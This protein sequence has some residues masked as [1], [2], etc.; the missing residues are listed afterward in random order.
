[1]IIITDENP[2]AQFNHDCLIHPGGGAGCKGP[3]AVFTLAAL[4]N[5]N[6]P[7]VVLCSNGIKEAY[8]K[9][10]EYL[11]ARQIFDEAFPG[12]GE[13]LELSWINSPA[14]VGDET[15]QRPTTDQVEN[16]PAPTE[17]ELPEH[18]ENVTT[19]EQLEQ[20]EDGVPVI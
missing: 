13:K 7:N 18:D 20:D 11:N 1:M 15:P 14:E 17:A 16:K 5:P 9:L 19:L 4:E 8:H 12:E 3:F 6:A 10:G 2:N